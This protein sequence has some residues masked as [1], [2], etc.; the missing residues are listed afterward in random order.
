MKETDSGPPFMDAEMLIKYWRRNRTKYQLPLTEVERSEKRRK[1]E[2]ES[3]LERQR[4]RQ[5]RSIT[6]IVPDLNVKNPK[7]SFEE[8]YQQQTLRKRRI[9]IEELQERAKEANLRL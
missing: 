1:L 6:K 3:E 8:Y 2:K 5:E 4:L 9:E 7:G